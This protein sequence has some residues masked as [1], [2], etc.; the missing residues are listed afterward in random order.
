H[1]KVPFGMHEYLLFALRIVEPDFI[2]ADTAQR[3]VGLDAT[4]V[5]ITLVLRVQAIS[6]IRRHLISIV[7]TTHNDWLIR[8][9]LQKVHDNFLPN[10]R[11]EA[12][13]PSFAG[14]KLANTYPARAICVV[15]AFLVPMKLHLHPA[16]FIGEKLFVRRTDHDGRLGSGHGRFRSSSRWAERQID[17]QTCETVVVREPCACRSIVIL[18]AAMQYGC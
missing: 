9:T 10:A 3:G 12:R 7:N 6:Q 2:E 15:F 4:D 16:V 1:L 8:V 17:W 13:T 11:P 5:W 14:P 18:P